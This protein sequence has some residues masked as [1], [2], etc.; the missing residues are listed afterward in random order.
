MLKKI[1]IVSIILGFALSCFGFWMVESSGPFDYW[2][3][4]SGTR[5]LIELAPW[6]FAILGG[7]GI[8]AGIFYLVQG[9]KPIIRKNA[10]VIEKNGAVVTFEFDDGS[11]KNLTLMKISVIVGEEGTIG[12][13]GNFAVEFKKR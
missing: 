6:L 8:L 11:R 13:Q 10:K 7:L 9:F 4:S 5:T 12:Y 1:G 3:Y 2:G